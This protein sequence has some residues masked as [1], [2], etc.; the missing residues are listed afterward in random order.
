MI[1]G[2]ESVVSIATPYDLHGSG[3]EFRLGQTIFFSP[4]PSRQVQ[5]PVQWVL[6]SFSRG[7]AAWA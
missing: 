4:H 5:P 2:S 6:G 1:W 3:V 7:K